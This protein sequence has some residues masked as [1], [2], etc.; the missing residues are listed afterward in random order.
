MTHVK[1][2]SDQTAHHR[3]R[4][5]IRHGS[6]HE[7]NGQSHGDT[8]SECSGMRA[9]AIA[10]HEGLLLGLSRLRSYEGTALASSYESVADV[11]GLRSVGRT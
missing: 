10:N 6:Q 1:G 11:E 3:L 5:N 9:S 8:S 2:P 4:K 7:S